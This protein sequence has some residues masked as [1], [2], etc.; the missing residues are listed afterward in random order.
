MNNL[1]AMNTATT[2]KV[3]VARSIITKDFRYRDFFQGG[4]WPW[5]W[6]IARFDQLSRFQFP[7]QIAFP[8]TRFLQ[9][10]QLLL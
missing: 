9:G 3:A 2:T 7:G 10:R 4:Y 8:V 6:L 1:V 5:S